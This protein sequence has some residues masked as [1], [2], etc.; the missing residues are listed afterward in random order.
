MCVEGEL[1]VCL[2]AS[3]LSVRGLDK[4]GLHGHGRTRAMQSRPRLVSPSETQILSDLR[5]LICSSD[6][7]ARD[8]LEHIFPLN[9]IYR[10]STPNFLLRQTVVLKHCLASCYYF[11]MHIKTQIIKKHISPLTS[12]GICPKICRSFVFFCAQVWRYELCSVI[13]VTATVNNAAI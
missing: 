11:C 8:T 1:W 3:V 10:R 2:S 6:W 7:K 9:C 12:S 4:A 5:G 13:S